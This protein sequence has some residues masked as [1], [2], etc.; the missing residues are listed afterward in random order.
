MWLA[1]DGLVATGAVAVLVAVG[2]WWWVVVLVAVVSIVIG[3][4]LAL[5][6]GRGEADESGVGSQVVKG[7]V[8]AGSQV[9]QVGR[10]GDSSSVS[11]TRGVTETPP[12]RPGPAV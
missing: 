9:V 6:G 4:G 5:A 1:V 8:G 3:L 7:P 11:V 12:E 10:V 2:A